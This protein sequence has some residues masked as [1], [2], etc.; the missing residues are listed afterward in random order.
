[1]RWAQHAGQTLYVVDAGANT[2]YSVKG[3]FTAG[4]AIGSLDTVGIASAGTEIDTLN[5]ATG[6]L[7]PFIKG[8]GTAKGLLFGP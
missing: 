1:M 7:T 5:T 6:A 3:P 4:E 2:I 8:F